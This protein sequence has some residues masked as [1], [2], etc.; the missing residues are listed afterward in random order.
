[1]YTLN[2]RPFMRSY[3]ERTQLYQ[4]IT[5]D[6]DQIRYKACTATGRLYDAFE[7]VRRP[8]EPNEIKES[9]IDAPVRAAP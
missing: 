7:L 8:G 9:Q 1:M 2:K 3:A 6:G 4:V 5:V